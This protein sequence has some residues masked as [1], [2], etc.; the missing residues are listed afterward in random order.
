VTGEPWLRRRLF[1]AAALAGVGGAL[2]GKRAGAGP[3]PETSAVDVRQFGAKGDGTSDDAPAINRAIQYLRD[4]MVQVPPFSFAPRLVFP[5][6]V[7]AVDSPLNLTRLWALNA[8]IDGQGSV[9]RGRC[10]GQPVIDA[11][12]SRWLTIRDLTVVGD[13]DSPPRIGLQIGR[14]NDGRV[15]D[16]HCLIDIK[17]V[18]HFSL[19]CL[20]NNGAETTGFD[21]VFCWNDHPGSYCLIQ[22]GLS[23]FGAFSSFVPDQ[24][25][26][27]EGDT[28]FNE[29]EFIN[30]D[31]RHGGEGGVP[32]WLGDTARHRF[33]RC[34]AAS[35]GPVSFVIYCGPNS[36]SL[37]DVDCHCETERLRSVF[38]VTGTTDEVTIRGLSFKEHGAFA[39]NSV[40]ERC[41]PVMRVNVQNVRIEISHFFGA[42]CRVL[43]VPESWKMN[44]TIYINE[45][46]QW[47]GDSVFAGIVYAKDR[48]YTVGLSSR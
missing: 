30:C 32:V 36:H 34:Y 2:P 1:R 44:G 47:N 8:V 6:G 7:Y 29:N 14:L 46:D 35:G 9:I 21:H 16:N 10:R 27:P 45:P 42:S 37:L 31:F 17:M 13:R 5:G 28:S 18:G 11:L 20:L 38:Q 40:F 26:G 12:G 3:L 23:H 15:A 43:D 19:A 41:A 24:R 39:R 22:D 33:C 25:P 48:A 4:H